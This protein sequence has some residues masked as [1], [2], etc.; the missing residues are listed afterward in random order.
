MDSVAI[1]IPRSRAVRGGDRFEIFGD[2]GTGVI[3]SS[4]PLT[5]RPIPFWEGLP[6]R[7][8][9]L[10]DGHLAG[11]HLDNIIPDG[12]LA[13][14]HLCGEHVWPAASLVFISS[15]HYFG[16][17]GF[18]ARTVDAGGNIS[19]ALSPIVARFVNS[20]P[21]FAT[22]LTKSGFDGGTRRM[23]FTFTPSPDL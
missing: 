16:V 8:G 14:R 13:G 15:P 23:T 18:A 2:D 22:D 11:C 20:S 19:A 5:D 4:R 7:R 12:H 1:E 17:F 3:D 21:R 6:G 10:L 9:H